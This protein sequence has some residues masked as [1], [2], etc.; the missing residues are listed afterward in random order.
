MV[1]LALRSSAGGG[2]DAAAVSVACEPL[3]SEGAIP[4]SLAAPEL[5]AA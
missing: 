2:D 5:P 3:G 4:L 1:P